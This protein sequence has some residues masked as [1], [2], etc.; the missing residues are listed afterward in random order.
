MQHHRR[1]GKLYYVPYT[2]G[3]AIR[4]LVGALNLDDLNVVVSIVVVE[5]INGIDV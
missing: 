5:N 2:N 4:L 3:I 1:K